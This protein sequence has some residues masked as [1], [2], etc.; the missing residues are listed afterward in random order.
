MDYEGTRSQSDCS[1]N[2]GLNEY[3]NNIIW[4]IG[5]ACEENGLP[6]P[7]VITESGR[8]VTAHHTVLVSNIIGVERNEY[9][10]ATPPAEDAAR[11]LQSMWETWL[12]MHETGN[13]RSLREWLHD[14]QMDLHDIHIGY[15]SGTFNL[16]ERAWAEQLYLNMCHEVQKQLDPSNR[17]HRPII[18]ELQER[19]A[20]KIYVNFSLFQSMPDALGSISCSR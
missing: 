17:A 12:E 7:T 20:D 14:S 16:Q 1:V 10:E 2:Y 6:H 11:P 9:T 3:A 15:S 8:A 18:D 5:D 4:A 13:R 19:M